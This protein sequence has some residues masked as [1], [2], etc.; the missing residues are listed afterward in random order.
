MIIASVPTSEIANA[1]TATACAKEI[2][3]PKG[4]WIAHAITIATGMGLQL[5]GLYAAA[6][7][8]GGWTTLGL[9][10]VGGLAVLLQRAVLRRT[11]CS[12]G[13]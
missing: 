4:F 12:P 6:V 9:Y 11:S 7:T 5:V 1:S 8:F 3:M 13:D 10:A 2:A